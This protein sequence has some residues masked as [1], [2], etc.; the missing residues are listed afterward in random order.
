[1][2]EERWNSERLEHQGATFATFRDSEGATEDIVVART[3][4]SFTITNV[5]KKYVNKIKIINISF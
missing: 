5:I 4:R 3:N 2:P 1:V